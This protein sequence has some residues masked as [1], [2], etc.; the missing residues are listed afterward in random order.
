MVVQQLLQSSGIVTNMN[1]SFNST[2]FRADAE[3]VLQ[4]VHSVRKSLIVYTI[5]AVAFATLALSGLEDGRKVL[6]R[7]FWFLGGLFGGAPHN[8][9]LPGPSGLP[10]V[11][12]LFDVS[13]S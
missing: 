3:D 2:V 9:A 8:V 10:L 5:A 7:L 6:Q 13:Y 1:A 4:A 11:G 12:N